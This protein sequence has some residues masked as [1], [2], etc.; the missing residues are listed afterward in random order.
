MAPL[1]CAVDL[2]QTIHGISNITADVFI[3]EVAANTSRF[4][5][6][7]HRILSAR[8]CPRNDESAGKRWSPRLRNSGNWLKTSLVT[9]A[10][11]VARKKHSCMRSHSLRFKP[12]RAPTKAILAV[13][14]TMLTA[15][16]CIRRNGVEYHDLGSA[17]FNRIH[18]TKAISRLVRCFSHFVCEMESTHTACRFNRKGAR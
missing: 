10:S 3:A 14:A 2:L 6:A 12:R 7:R 11:A 9:A 4:P 17:Y 8:L 1:V 18:K 15:A 16:H 13:A 5:S